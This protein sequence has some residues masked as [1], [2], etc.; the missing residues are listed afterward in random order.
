MPKFCCWTPHFWQCVSPCFTCF[1]HRSSNFPMT[2]R[3][4]STPWQEDWQRTSAPRNGNMCWVS[5]TSMARKSW[6][7]LVHLSSGSD[8]H[9]IKRT[10][11]N[12]DSN[13]YVT[14]P[15]TRHPARKRPALQSWWSISSYSQGVPWQVVN[16][17]MVKT[18]D[19]PAIHTCG[20]Y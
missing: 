17:S 15:W 3:I 9:E 2:G 5:R 19:S 13:C 16:I 11:A 14:Y 8:E 12:Y 20:I 18:Y 1:P 7:W 4:Y 10:R 6:S